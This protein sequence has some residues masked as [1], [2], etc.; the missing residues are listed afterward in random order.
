MVVSDM[1]RISWMLLIFFVNHIAFSHF[2]LFIITF[3][4]TVS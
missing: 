1:F 3:Q 4:S 2:N